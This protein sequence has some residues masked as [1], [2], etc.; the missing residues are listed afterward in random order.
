MVE[1]MFEK[2]HSADFSTPMTQLL[3]LSVGQNVFRMCGITGLSSV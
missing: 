2:M 1:K 3:G